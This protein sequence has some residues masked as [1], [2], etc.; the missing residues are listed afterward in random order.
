MLSVALS[1]LS[2]H[3]HHARQARRARRV[4]HARHAC[5]AFP[6]RPSRLLGA[7]P[8][9]GLLLLERLELFRQTLNLVIFRVEPE[10]RLQSCLPITLLMWHWAGG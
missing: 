10:S 4:R 8:P 6:S 1:L 5:R 7:L 9:R 3:A 2:R